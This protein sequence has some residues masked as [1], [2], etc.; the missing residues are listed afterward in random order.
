MEEGCVSKTLKLNE[1]EMA[2]FERNKALASL[3][4]AQVENQFGA[5]RRE[6]SRKNSDLWK[7]IEKRLK[8]DLKLY[9]ANE[10]TG[11]L[12]LIEAVKKGAAK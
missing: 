1:L 8:I 12:E 11:A 5:R 2:L 4:D 9:A 3:V 7:R 10:E 6:I